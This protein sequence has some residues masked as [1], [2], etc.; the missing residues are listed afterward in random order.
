MLN[1]TVDGCR[2][3][4]WVEYN[5]I[6]RQL[7]WRLSTNKQ[8]WCSW[9]KWINI[10]GF[11]VSFSYVKIE[12]SS[13]SIKNMQATS[14]CSPRVWI[15]LSNVGN[16]TDPSL[17]CC[18]NLDRQTFGT[19][20]LIEFLQLDQICHPP[21]GLLPMQRDSFAI[22]SSYAHLCAFVPLSCCIAWFWLW[23][24]QVVTCIL[25]H[26]VDTVLC[27]HGV[28]CECGWFGTVFCS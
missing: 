4:H 3:N 7:G 16:G 15:T 9:S 26:P 18:C 12:K 21:P 10:L 28:E 23:R 27:H 2:G 1:F 5:H 19:N 25:K 17:Q 22:Q 14:A 11:Q 13:L 8:C 24:A 20:M 6:E